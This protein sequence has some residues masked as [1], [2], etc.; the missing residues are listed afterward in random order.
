[1]P[2]PFLSF[3]EPI[4]LETVFTETVVKFGRQALHTTSWP[5]TLEC[6]NMLQDKEL[7]TEK[8]T[9]K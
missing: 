5:P 1:M 9:A 3:Y 2:R 6:V 4:A 8:V 7:W